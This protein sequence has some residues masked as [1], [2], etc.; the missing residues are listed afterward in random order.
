MSISKMMDRKTPR[1]HIQNTGTNVQ[2]HVL[3]K[4]Q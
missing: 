4:T 1:Y 3:R 2:S